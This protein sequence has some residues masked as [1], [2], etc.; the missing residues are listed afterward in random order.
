MQQYKDCLVYNSTLA[1]IKINYIIYCRNCR[2][3]CYNTFLYL[4]IFLVSA[5]ISEKLLVTFSIFS[6]S[7]RGSANFIPFHSHS[8]EHHFFQFGGMIVISLK[9]PGGSLYLVWSEHL[10]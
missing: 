6:V 1:S 8:S 2:D 10:S 3:F 9:W 5:L 7:M 4:M